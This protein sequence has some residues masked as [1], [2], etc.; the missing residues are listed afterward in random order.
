MRGAWHFILASA[1]FFT[2][3]NAS[4]TSALAQPP[5][6]PSSPTSTQTP[7]TPP[8]P[9]TPRSYYYSHSVFI[10]HQALYIHGGVVSINSI[11]SSQA[12]YID[13]S[14][15]WTTAQP[16]FVQ[17]PDGYPVMGALSGLTYNNTK[18]LGVYNST[19]CTFD[20]QPRIWT[21]LGSSEFVTPRVDLPAVVNPDDN[22]F[23][24]LNGWVNNRTVLG[25]LRFD[26]AQQ[27]V[28]SQSLVVP[29]DGSFTSVWSTMRKAAFVFGGYTLDSSTS[30]VAQRTLFIYQPNVSAGN[31]TPTLRNAPDSGAIPSARYGHCMVEAY[32]GTKMILFGGFDQVGRALGDIYILD[33]ATLKWTRGTDGGTTAARAYTACAVTND[34]FVAW[35]GAMPD[36][37]TQFAS[38]VSQNITIVYNLK[39]LQWQTTYHPEPYT[40]PPLVT[41]TPTAMPTP[42]NTGAGGRLSPTAVTL[43]S[44]AGGILLGLSLIAIGFGVRWC[45]RRRKATRA[46]TSAATTTPM[47]M[48]DRSFEGGGGGGHKTSIHGE[49]AGGLTV[50]RNSPYSDSGFGVG[51]VPH[52]FHRAEHSNT[53]TSF[54]SDTA[55]PPASLYTM[56]PIPNPRPQ[57]PLPLP[58]PLP[59]PLPSAVSGHT[60]YAPRP[61]LPARFS[62]ASTASVAVAHI[63][64]EGQDEE[65]EFEED[66]HR[67][68]D[69]VITPVDS[70]PGRT[71]SSGSRDTSSIANAVAGSNASNTHE[72]D[73]TSSTF[74]ND[75]GSGGL[76]VGAG[77]GG[78]QKGRSGTLP[79]SSTEVDLQEYLN[80]VQFIQQQQ[81][82][83]KEQQEQG[84]QQLG[85]H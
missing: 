61:A 36:P 64:L 27:R 73:W 82:K 39:T 58:H 41:A 35:G 15:N 34:L 56:R 22:Q 2:S 72:F 23:F 43:I 21:T 49:Q 74:S 81:Q 37:Q 25:T 12:F 26:T 57:L 9:Y 50:G 77:E 84:Q 31:S 68:A 6:P 3:Q 51:S 54:S 63:P 79:L 75:L 46:A 8:A 62:V 83:E 42:T 14:Q 30:S 59:R 47:P 13:L 16:A 78:G 19:I 60:S 45:R 10:E 53:P 85:A 66:D 38:A 44:L 52:T 20:L 24:V 28:F 71:I 67:E 80:Y 48:M 5:P 40:P 7:T 69:D 29:L 4:K 18:W 65:D 32:N 17:L 1:L 33:V 11:P 70:L 55:P 76:A